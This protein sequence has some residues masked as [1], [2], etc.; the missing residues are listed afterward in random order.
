MPDPV[1]AVVRDLFFVA[2]I[3]ETARMVDAP[4]SFARTPEELASALGAGPA[5]LVLV[6]LTM[7][8]ADYPALFS[9]L[10]AD[11]RGIPVLG[12]TTH[13]LAGQTK[14][15]HGRCARVV[16]RETLTRELGTILAHGAAAARA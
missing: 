9:V 1:I 10:E 11:G 5:G 15:L 4:L 3:R 6:D 8:G 14:P 16:T 12:Y 7:P 13:V 2:R